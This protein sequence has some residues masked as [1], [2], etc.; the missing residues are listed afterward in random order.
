MKNKDIK[1]QWKKK[2]IVPRTKS[3]L[4]KLEKIHVTVYEFKCLVI[5]VFKKCSGQCI[6]FATL[7]R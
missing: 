3:L 5:N 6:R 1:S 7:R 2:Q 4:L